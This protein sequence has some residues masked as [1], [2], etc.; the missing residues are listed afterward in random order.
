MIKI[1]SNK[2]FLFTLLF[3]YNC[4]AFAHD[5][6][7]P[8]D[9]EETAGYNAALAI[10]G[11]VIALGAGLISTWMPPE[12]PDVPESDFE[13]EFGEEFD[14]EF[15]DEF[16]D[17]FD[18]DNEDEFDDDEFDSD[19]DNEEK[20][21]GNEDEDEEDFDEDEDSDDDKEDEEKLLE[22]KLEIKKQEEKRQRAL[23]KLKEIEVLKKKHEAYVN[24]L[25]KK[26]HTTP[27]KLRNV[28]REKMKMS[29]AEADSWN[30]YDKK[31]AYAEAAAKVTL[32]A[33]DTAIDALANVTGKYGEGIRAG[34]KVT[35]GIAST[36][37]DKGISGSSFTSGLVK[38]GA[39]AATDFIE[40]PYL[41]AG[42]TIAGET[43]GGAI[44]DGK[45]GAVDGFVNGAITAIVNEG[46]GKLAGPGFG[47]E[48]K[49]MIFNKN[50]TASVTIKSGGKWI[51]KVISGKNAIK[52]ANKKIYNQ[53]VESGV[54]GT[55]ST[56]NEFGLKPGLEWIKK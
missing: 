27:E 50:G 51:T 9:C 49:P 47:N 19:D 20:D 48:M 11:G 53:F 38:G 40:N 54:K 22:R 4:V 56:L 1:I 44:T 2:Y 14:D 36:M 13:N 37:A 7:S 29:Q 10:T 33:A 35:K 5:C 24:K 30:R 17:E 31:L 55:S 28:L 21:G 15:D 43:I 46:T 42:T 16:S 34:Y 41:K 12:V 45:K 39:D 32:I 52:F 26:Y 3:L 8:G 6:S 23:E 18:E 25:S